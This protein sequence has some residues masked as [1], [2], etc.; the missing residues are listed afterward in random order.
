M[1]M[2]YRTFRA[3]VMAQLGEEATP[4]LKQALAAVKR[5]DLAE[6]VRLMKSAKAILKV[7]DVALKDAKKTRSLDEIAADHYAAEDAKTTPVPAAPQKKTIAG[8]IASLGADYADG[9]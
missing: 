9:K 7:A 1:K 5:R 3:Q 6:A 4:L 8:I 2:P